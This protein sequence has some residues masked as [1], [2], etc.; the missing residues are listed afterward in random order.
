MVGISSQ[1]VNVL[2]SP[3]GFEKPE[4][5]WDCVFW[6]C[7]GRRA[8]EGLVGDGGR[9]RTKQFTRSWVETAKYEYLEYLS[10]ETRVATLGR[11]LDVCGNW[12]LRITCDGFSM[13]LLGG[14]RK[15]MP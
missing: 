2:L 1:L 5:S 10:Y 7:G 15:G 4:R 13:C 11:V 3:N 12:A 6:Y 14:Y 8:S 9:P